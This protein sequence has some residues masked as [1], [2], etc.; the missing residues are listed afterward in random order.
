MHP[1]PIRIQKVVCCS[2]HAV[3]GAA[4]GAL[5]N[6]AINDEISAEIGARRAR[7]HCRFVCTTARPLYT[8]LT[9]SQIY[10]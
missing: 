9:N 7:L 3:R 4:A 10:F 6:L 5:R 1:A 2:Q 8:R